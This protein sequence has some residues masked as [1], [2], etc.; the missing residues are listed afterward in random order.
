LL[1]RNPFDCVISYFNLEV[2]SS[3]SEDMGSLFKEL[4]L[5]WNEFTKTQFKEYARLYSYWL[6]HPMPKHVTRFE[7]YI[8]NKK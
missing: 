1:A 3:H 2:T 5:E 6:K 7:D 4:D 8:E